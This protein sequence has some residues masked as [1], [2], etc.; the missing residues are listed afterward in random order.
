M[1][2]LTVLSVNEN[3][4]ESKKTF[5]DLKRG[6]F[7]GFIKTLTGSDASESSQQLKN[8]LECRDVNE[9]SSKG[10]TALHACAYLKRWELAK[11]LLDNG[12]NGNIRNNAGHTF[13][14]TVLKNPMVEWGEVLKDYKEQWEEVERGLNK[15]KRGK[16][17]LNKV[18]DIDLFDYEN[19]IFE[20]LKSND[21]DS[22]DV[23]KKSLPEKVYLFKSGDWWE[24]IFDLPKNLIIRFLDCGI[25]LE[26]KNF[27]GTNPLVVLTERNDLEL[28][29]IFLANGFNIN[30]MDNNGK[31][32]L[33]C[34]LKMNSLQIFEFLINFGVD[35]K[36]KSKYLNN[37]T[38][39]EYAKANNYEEIVEILE[40]E[41]DLLSVNKPSNFE[42]KP[43]NKKQ[44]KRG[45]AKSNEKCRTKR[46]HFFVAKLDGNLKEA[47]EFD[48]LTARPEVKSTVV[49]VKRKRTPLIGHESESNI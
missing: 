1:S 30:S 9:Q 12:A 27:I 21:W 24:R 29:K 31:S 37:L 25:R 22:L 40:I 5:C 48:Y 42:K 39:L 36:S 18:G 26:K 20:F 7:Y 28:L 17:S 19:T 3:V 23:Y 33:V 49:V 43:F 14:K 34:A 41:L 44:K 32:A 16:K 15:N 38:P 6:S 13:W 8:A 47:Q 46:E 4:N 10:S 35:L 2:D 45:I 11:I